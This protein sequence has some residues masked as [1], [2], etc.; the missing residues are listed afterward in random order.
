MTRYGSFAD[1][2]AGTA[3]STT[4]SAR[5]ASTSEAE[6]LDRASPLAHIT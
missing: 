1:P 4:I 2:A 5:I 3:K 6:R